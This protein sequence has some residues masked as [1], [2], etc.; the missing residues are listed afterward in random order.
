MTFV[1]AIRCLSDGTQPKTFVLSQVIPNITSYIIVWGLQSPLCHRVALY[2]VTLALI[3]P[4]ERLLPHVIIIRTKCLE[5]IVLKLF[6]NEVNILLNPHSLLIDKGKELTMPP[7]PFSIVFITVRNEV[8]PIS[9]FHLL[10][11]PSSHDH[12]PASTNII[13]MPGNGNLLNE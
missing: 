1:L 13:C 8:V 5:H 10:S 9:E 2:T 7:Q 3:L 11:L 4:C 6:L 12:T